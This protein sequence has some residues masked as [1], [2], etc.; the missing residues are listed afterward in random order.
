M[1]YLRDLFQ[2]AVPVATALAIIFIALPTGLTHAADPTQAAPFG[3]TSAPLN[4]STTTQVK[5]GGLGV[6]VLAV[7]GASSFGGGLEMTATSTGVLLPRLTTAERDAIVSPVKGMLVYNT[8]TTY[9][10][11]YSGSAWGVCS[12]GGGSTGLAGE[13][14]VTG[15]NVGTNTTSESWVDISGMSKKRLAQIKRDELGLV[16]QS[17]YLFKGFSGT[18][19]LEVAAILSKQEIDKE[20]LKRLNINESINQKVTE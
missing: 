1:K 14:S 4:V 8:E 16:F 10:E 19:N 7:S 11:C 17:H 9:I 15:S 6:S 3:N 20:L 5:L 2:T 18:E 13:R 12:V